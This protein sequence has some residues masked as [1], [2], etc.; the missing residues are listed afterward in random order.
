MTSLQLNGVTVTGSGTVPLLH[1]VDLAVDSGTTLAIL[2]PSAATRTALIR[3]LAGLDRPDQGEVVI[4]E[5]DLTRADA[6]DRQVAVVLDDFPV[7]PARTVRAALT[8]GRGVDPDETDGV[9]DLLALGDLLDLRP[10]DLTDEQRQRLALAR[11]LGREASLYL[12][13]DPWSQQSPRVRAHIRSM[14][15]RWQEDRDR[16]T[17]FTTPLVAEALAVADAVAVVHGGRLLQVGT[18]R[19]VYDHPADLVVASLVGD[20]AINLVPGIVRG[21]RVH[22]PVGGLALSP[23]RADLLDGR[24][25]VVVGLR[26]EHLADVTRGGADELTGFDA[27]SR[28]DEI[29]W[30]GGDQLAYLGF[31]LEDGVQETLEA[32]EDRHGFDLFQAFIVARLSAEQVLVPGQ[33]L[34]IAAPSARALLFD[35]AT[36]ENLEPAH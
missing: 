2:S 16:T 27:T 21:T 14:V 13:D 15:Q 29:E 36:G 34:H 7:L 12:L 23:D 18:P 17:V 31:D 11:A 30:R 9:I 3:V 10:R 33:S 8:Q 26:P 35:A 24:D 5:T 20:P 4:D 25:A 22:T 32:I 19:E 1:E 28:I 6:R